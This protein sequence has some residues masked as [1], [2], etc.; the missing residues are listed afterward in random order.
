MPSI[1]SRLRTRAVSQTSRHSAQSVHP[2]ATTVTTP[3]HDEQADKEGRPINE[4]S[5]QVQ[6][7]A[8][9]TRKIYR[10]LDLLTNE[11]ATEPSSI[12]R[13]LSPPV[14]RGPPSSSN[15][16]TPILGPVEP[17]VSQA[18]KGDPDSPKVSQSS[19][20]SGNSAPNGR[21][22]IERLGDWSTFG[23]RRAPPP[24]LNE[25]GTA[26]V[27]PSPSAWRAVRANSRLSSRQSSN[28]TT[29]S[30]HSSPNENNN[31]NTPRLSYQSS[32]DR[33]GHKRISTF[34]A[35]ELASDSSPAHSLE[36]P[37]PEVNAHIVPPLPPL[38]HPA[39]RSRGTTATFPP[40]A[41]R[42]SMKDDREITLGR[43]TFRKSLRPYRSLPRVQNI[44]K[45]RLNLE[46]GKGDVLSRA[47]DDDGENKGQGTVPVPTVG[48]AN[49][50][51][52]ARVSVPILPVPSS[53]IPTSS[54]SS[55]SS[56]S[57]SSKSAPAVDIHDPIPVASNLNDPHI[58][59]IIGNVV[60]MQ[61][62]V[63]R[64]HDRKPLRSSLKATARPP[65]ASSSSSNGA[66]MLAA[67]TTSS[68]GAVPRTPVSSPGRSEMAKGKRKA[69]DVDTTPPDPKKATFAVPGVPHVFFFS[70]LLYY[71]II[72]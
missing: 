46:E 43:F 67:V 18:A 11:L 1:L 22:F 53:I 2:T 64:V 65:I 10:D 28:R 8:P 17:S 72:F 62:D 40:R 38:E 6:G 42:A 57:S 24:S 60:P 5:I 30:T 66:H 49:Q 68:D 48:T 61:Q 7:S 20:S 37:S 58:L 25:F 59:S 9:V 71:V 52:P 27:S 56:A 3:T 4:S 45:T 63:P 29:A 44:F 39:L 32:S 47:G 14:R 26:Q 23:R 36:H 31:N 33:R 54:S 50:S 41:R 12:H 21:G 16:S 69:E 13:G 55:P 34:G 51:P 15:P 70:S 19:N 35:R